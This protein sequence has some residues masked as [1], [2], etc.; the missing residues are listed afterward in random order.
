MRKPVFRNIRVNPVGLASAAL[1]LAAPFLPWLTVIAYA[2]FQNLAFPQFAIRSDLWA[3]QQGRVPVNV[4]QGLPVVALITAVLLILGG[5]LSI[6]R[7]KLGSGAAVVGLV[8]FGA[9]S[10]P[11]YGTS[12]T[13]ALVV[14]VIPD[15][16]LF[17]AI[18]G[19]V[20]AVIS[21]R[22]EERP[23]GTLIQELRTRQGLTEL[24]LLFAV[25]SLSLDGLTHG[26][27]GQLSVFL[28]SSVVEMGLHLS[29]FSCI[30]GLSVVFLVSR[31][32]VYSEGFRLL[33]LGAF[34]FLLADG[35]Y[36]LSLG[37]LVDFIGHDSSEIVLHVATYYGLA[38]LLIAELAL[39]RGPEV[40]S[41]SPP[42]LAALSD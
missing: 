30:T 10:Y 19:A 38:F 16:G 5:L 32:S 27:L 33:T 28:G 7:P 35:L 13:G 4:P 2:V 1:L 23:L 41:A 29:F 6:R 34:I 21:T 42:E 22:I 3:I 31:R 40:S 11:S 25:V 36:H 26:A 20:L 17:S 8:L 24:G 9:V 14:S 37:Q 15:L 18:V 39:K 12:Q